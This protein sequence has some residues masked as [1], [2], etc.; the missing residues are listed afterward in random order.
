MKRERISDRV[1]ATLEKRIVEGMYP[2]GSRLPPERALAEELGVSRPSLRE[3]LNK[4]GVHGLI[5]SRQGGGHRV[6]QQLGSSFSDP[7]MALLGQYEDIQY[8]L[9]EYRNAL[10]GMAA[11]YAA[12]RSN[13][14]DHQKLRDSFKAIEQAHKAGQAEAEAAA[15]AAFHLAIVEAS[16]NVVLLHNM[17][18]LFQLL[19]SSIA[20]S[21]FRFA[22]QGDTGR[23][24]LHQHEH[25]LNTI[26]AGDPRG[27]QAASMDHLGYV[28]ECLEEIERVDRR[29]QRGLRRFRVQGSS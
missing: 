26:L 5:E 8:D 16:H 11:W 24:L 13:T 10:E 7:L 4:L 1:A 23:N 29:R 22:G 18:A 17:K 2:A 3:A 12:I 19:S 28:E 20:D 21:V 6:C 14:E 9:L 27:A 25:L 15:D